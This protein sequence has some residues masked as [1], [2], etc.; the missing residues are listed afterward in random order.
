MCEALSRSCDQVVSQVEKV[1][2]PSW[3]MD[4]QGSR[5]LPDDTLCHTQN[6]KTVTGHSDWGFAGLNGPGR[7]LQGADI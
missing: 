1:L 6:D 4:G 7:L 5:E 2:L 3:W